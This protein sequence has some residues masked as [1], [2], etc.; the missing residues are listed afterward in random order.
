MK[1][2]AIVVQRCHPSVVGGSEALAWQYAS[3]LKQQYEVDILTTTALDISDWANVLPA[4]LEVHDGLNIRRFPVTIGRT[5][6]WG[7]LHDRLS[8]EYPT[9]MVR[10]KRL[11][12]PSFADWSLSL[13]EE[14]I[15]TQGPYSVELNEFLRTTWPE[16]HAIV[17]LTYLYPTTYFGLLQVPKDYA[18]L[19]PT[20]HDESPAYLS[21]YK[22]SARRARS[23][24]WLTEAER[25]VSTDLWGDLPGTVISAAIETTP[26]PPANL[27][28]P[29][30]L[31]CGRIDPNKGCRQLFDYFIRYKSEFP[32]ET[33][34]VLAGKD[35][36]P[37]PD[38][39]DIDFRGFVSA[40]E[41]YSL[42]AGASILVMPSRNESF[43]FVTMEAMAQGT[44]VL[45][46]DG[47]EVLVDHLVE[48]RAGKLFNNYQSFAAALEDMLSDE[49]ELR[50]MGRKG[51]EYVVSRFQPANIL[52]SLVSAI[53]TRSAVSP[54]TS[55]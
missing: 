52:E 54:F 10:K 5:S 23:L 48:S 43:S 1:K 49:G 53:E 51:R 46:S 40:E 35:D 33:I 2:V 20:L 3:L 13:Q 18:F 41:K 8:T 14:F 55:R 36:F 22:Y 9:R 12:N 4:G 19:V 26:R 11:P 47:S 28:A 34:L 21:A 24:L 44:P 6:S 42:M 17:F 29:Y 16:Y 15:R 31:Y 45:A 50:E 7:F 38:H 37:V 25:R 27:S 30:I 39:P 32:S